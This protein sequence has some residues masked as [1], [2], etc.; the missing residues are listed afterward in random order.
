MKWKPQDIVALILTC[1]VI[2]IL[3]ILSIKSFFGVEPMSD[4]A[5]KI[6]SGIIG[7]IITIISIYI[8]TKLKK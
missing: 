1:G 8:G 3:L 2:V 7:S 5:A 6:T 4:E